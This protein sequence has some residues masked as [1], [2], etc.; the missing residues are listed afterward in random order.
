MRTLTLLCVL[1]V[2]AHL[3][4]S[5][6]VEPLESA[7]QEQ[8]PQEQQETLITLDLGD[9]KH[10]LSARDKRTIGFLRQLFP[11]LSQIIDNVIQSITRYLFRVIGRLV[12][13]GGLL[14]GG[15]GGGGGDTSSSS[16][17]DGNG[18]RRISITLPTYP[19]SADDDEDEEDN[20]EAAQS[21]LNP[22]GENQL[23]GAESQ[24]NEVRVQFTEP[25]Q[26]YDQESAASGGNDAVDGETEEDQR[27]KRFLNFGASA[28]ASGGSS[29]SSG[30]GSGGGS[31]NFLF[32]IIRLIAGSG[33][34]ESSDEGKSAEIS[35]GGDAHAVKDDG[36]QAGVPG[37]ITRL[38]VIA[39]RGLAN[40]MQDLIL[41][42]AQTSE[43]IVN[44]KARL[45]T[46]I[47]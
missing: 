42:L 5:L 14:G 35:A 47:I 39:N 37:P 30:S 27:N 23:A 44:F 28:D 33:N 1:C 6:P 31:G 13:R 26:S 24:Q 45:I 46:S 32:D 43:R 2:A 11:G 34:T 7:V 40:L 16:N 10:E 29:S 3:V 38:L 9:P 8:Q 17:S 20:T 25:E 22:E 12:L 19:P 41:R 15:G 4:A 36:Y 18:G 21:D